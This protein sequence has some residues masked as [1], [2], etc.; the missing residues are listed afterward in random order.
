MKLSAFDGELIGLTH[1][2][3]FNDIVL[4]NHRIWNEPGQSTPD[5]KT[6]CGKVRVNVNIKYTF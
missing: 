2:V 5:L 6:E 1:D 4:R 3:K